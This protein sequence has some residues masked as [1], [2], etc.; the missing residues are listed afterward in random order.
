MGVGK[1]GS[2]AV[3]VPNAKGPMD[4]YLVVGGCS[5]SVCPVVSVCESKQLG[6]ETD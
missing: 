6:F 2:K 5:G 4:R 1:Q 3:N